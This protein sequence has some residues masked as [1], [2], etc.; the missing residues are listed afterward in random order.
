MSRAL[1]IVATALVLALGLAGCG[2]DEPASKPLPAAK[3]SPSTPPGLDTTKPTPPAEV[4]KTAGSAGEFARY[5]A[6]VV[7]Y[8]VRIRDITPVAALARDQATCSSCRQL[9]DYIEGLKKDK[10]WD[11]RRRHRG[12]PSRW[13]GRAVARR[14]T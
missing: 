4:A 13:C 6:D 12:R 10:L 8:A 11:E 9:S 5:F 1:T 14:T 2:S 3:P 7:Q